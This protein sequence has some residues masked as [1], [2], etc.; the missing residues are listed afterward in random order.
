M[1]TSTK[2]IILL[3][4]LASV[5]NE[6]DSS[7]PCSLPWLRWVCSHLQKLNFVRY[8]AV[9]Y[10]LL[11]LPSTMKF[12]QNR[13]VSNWQEGWPLFLI[14]PLGADWGDCGL[15]DSWTITI[16]AAAAWAVA[17]STA[18]GLEHSWNRGR[19]G[20]CC[21]FS[22]CS[23]WQRFPSRVRTCLRCSAV[24]GWLRWSH[25]WPAWRHTSNSQCLKQCWS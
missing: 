5:Q 20:T 1:L 19:R 21:Y 9:V 11:T 4:L 2:T 3:S 17:V 22:A 14:D 24:R 6:R 7:L 12:S 18:A 8:S 16:A 10:F 15:G 23:R 13:S 25:R